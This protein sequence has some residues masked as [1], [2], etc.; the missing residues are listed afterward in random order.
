MTTTKHISATAPPPQTWATKHIGHRVSNSSNSNKSCPAPGPRAHR[1]WQRQDWRLLGL[2]SSPRLDVLPQHHPSS[3]KVFQLF[4]SLSFSLSH[5]TSLALPC[6]VSEGG[7]LSLSLSLCTEMRF[8]LYFSISL[9]LIA[10][11][12]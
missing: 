9:C 10:F 6:S 3:L 1:H 11:T 7:A 4:T 12:L 2:A 8:A 5:L